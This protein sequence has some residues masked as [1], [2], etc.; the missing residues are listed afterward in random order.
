[1]IEVQGNNA[2][3][4]RISLIAAML[5]VRTSIHATELGQ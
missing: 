2:N 5:A 1:M 4:L 3:V